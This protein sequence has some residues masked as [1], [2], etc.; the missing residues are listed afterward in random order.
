MPTSHDSG[1]KKKKRKTKREKETQKKREKETRKQKTLPTTPG[2]A[3]FLVLVGVW[4]LFWQHLSSGFC[5]NVNRNALATQRIE[6]SRGNPNPHAALP[7]D[8]VRVPSSSSSSSSSSSAGA[9]QEAGASSDETVVVPLSG[10]GDGGGGGGPQ[11]SEFSLRDVLLPV[12]G[13]GSS[14]LPTNAIGAACTELLA[15]DG[16][17]LPQMDAKPIGALPFKHY[18]VKIDPF[19]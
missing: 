4:S 19:S 11:C 2:P 10:G 12:L 15:A 9:A 16:L 3:P 6:M 18:S 13:R 5:C 14:V 1:A 7:G 17:S 8:L